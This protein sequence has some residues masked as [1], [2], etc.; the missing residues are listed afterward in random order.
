MSKKAI[1]ITLVSLIVL[2]IIAVVIYYIYKNKK[3]GISYNEN[4]ISGSGILIKDMPTPPLANL[5]TLQVKAFQDWMDIKHPNWVNGANLNKGVGYGNKGP[6]TMSAYNTYGAEWY[7]G[8]KKMSAATLNI[9]N[10]AM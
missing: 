7:D 2:G 1:I 10:L 4:P 9:A 3:S 8:V 5:N 6:A